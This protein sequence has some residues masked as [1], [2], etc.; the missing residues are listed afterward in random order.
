MKRPLQSQRK[1]LY[2]APAVQA[3]SEPEAAVGAD[4]LEHL[5][6]TSSEDTSSIVWVLALDQVGVAES[7]TVNSQPSHHDSDDADHWL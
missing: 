7:D 3:N 2:E 1:L 4:D 6:V 5:E